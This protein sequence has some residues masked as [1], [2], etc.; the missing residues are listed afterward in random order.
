[1]AG[2]VVVDA[3]ATFSQLVST[4]GNKTRDNFM[5]NSL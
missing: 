1:V 3:Q 5:I 2:V 4:M